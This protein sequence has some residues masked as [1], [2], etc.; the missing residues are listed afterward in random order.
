M[1]AI[2]G[3]I[4][5]QYHRPLSKLFDLSYIFPGH[6]DSVKRGLTVSDFFRMVVRNKSVSVRLLKVFNSNPKVP[7]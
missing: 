6:N 3:K 1:S 7:F 2:V 5:P 4:I